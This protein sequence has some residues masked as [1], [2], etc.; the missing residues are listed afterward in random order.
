MA[1][2]AR[3]QGKTCPEESSVIPLALWQKR[4]APD[5]QKGCQCGWNPVREG[6]VLVERS[7]DK[8]FGFYSFF[9]F[10][11]WGARGS[12]ES[13]ECH[14]LII[15]KNFSLAALC[16]TYCKWAGHKGKYGHQF[17]PSCS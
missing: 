13:R 15:F 12:M 4:G 3:N 7:C 17:G 10:F 11:Y 9:F 16:G 2:S 5:R 6:K 8:E 1:S 14:D